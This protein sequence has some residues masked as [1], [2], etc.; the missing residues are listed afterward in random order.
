MHEGTADWKADGCDPTWRRAIPSTRQWGL[1][2]GVGWAS[3]AWE[4][5]PIVSLSLEACILSIAIAC[6]SWWHQ[7]SRLDSIWKNIAKWALIT[8]RFCIFCFICVPE[9]PDEYRRQVC[10]I[11]FACLIFSRM[12][13]STRS[14]HKSW[15]IGLSSLMHMS[16]NWVHNSVFFI[17]RHA[18]NCLSKH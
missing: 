8:N 9:Q 4:S 3:S 7:V 5:Q 15:Q 18:Q 11:P 10:G 2:G 13:T 6:I 14:R 16:H 1:L 17:S 12:L